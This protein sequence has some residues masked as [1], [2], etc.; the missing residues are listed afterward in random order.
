[1]LASQVEAGR[2][3]SDY[4]VELIG[5]DSVAGG[6]CAMEIF[7]KTAK[8]LL[9]LDPGLKLAGYRGDGGSDAGLDPGVPFVGGFFFCHRSIKVLAIAEGDW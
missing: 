6:K 4:R 5:A 3:R 1:M 2:Q 7:R 9:Q 8:S